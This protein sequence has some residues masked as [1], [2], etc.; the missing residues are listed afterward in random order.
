MNVDRVARAMTGGRPRADFTARVMAPICGRPRPGFTAR[1]VAQAAPLAQGFRP[2]ARRAGFLLVPAAL[3][4]GAGLMVARASRIDLPPAPA[5]PTLA[6][7]TPAAQAWQVAQVFRPANQTPVARAF[8]PAAPG[9]HTTV[10]AEQ[11]PPDLPRIYTIPALEGPVD[12]AVRSIEVP[13]FTIRALDGPA[14]LTVSDLKGSKEQ[15]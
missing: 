6:T 11:A 15:P 8:R 12:I 5:A 9:A 4:L 10:P 2:G 7:A 1:V 13:A 3:A 14:P